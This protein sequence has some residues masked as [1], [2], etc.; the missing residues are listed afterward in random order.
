MPKIKINQYEIDLLLFTD[1]PF[2]LVYDE[3]PKGM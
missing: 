2:P 1:A 3:W